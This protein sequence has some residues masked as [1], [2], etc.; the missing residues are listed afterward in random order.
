MGDQPTSTAPTPMPGAP[1]TAPTPQP[2]QTPGAQP[3]PAASV[4]AAIQ[5][6]LDRAVKADAAAYRHEQ[7][8]KQATEKVA[9]LE[10]KL[11]AIDSDPFTWLTKE[12][13]IT[14]DMALERF[15]Q[16]RPG[17]SEE[18]LQL[19]QELADLKT[20]R[21]QV[22]QAEAERQRHQ[23]L[24]V[25]A[26]QARQLVQAAQD[27]DVVKAL[28][29]A[30]AVAGGQADFTGKVRAYQEQAKA[31]G[32]DLTPQ[33]AAVMLGGELAAMAKSLRAP[34]MIKAL[35]ALLGRAPSAEQPPPPGGTPAAPGRTL[36]SDM[37]HG[38]VGGAPPDFTKMTE[39]QERAYWAER[40][41][42]QVPKR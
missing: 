13:G 38:G 23:E 28:A 18:V 26:Q 4:D 17:P 42:G 32:V 19:R 27:P 40:Y 9:Q 2:G 33:Q 6:A 11:K 30:D 29:F 16:G 1:G 35:D 34:A 3:A 39:E 15:S 37:A 8:A 20:W 10:A 22:S 5:A 24:G 21:A 12:K 25:I 14:P 41:P 36:T 31:S 7:T